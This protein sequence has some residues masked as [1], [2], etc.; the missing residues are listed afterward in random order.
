MPKYDRVSRVRH[1]APA[2][3]KDQR[4]CVPHKGLHKQVHH[5][6]CGWKRHNIS[7]FVAQNQTWADLTLA[8]WVREGAP[9]GLTLASFARHPPLRAV[10]AFSHASEEAVTSSRLSLVE[11]CSHHEAFGKHMP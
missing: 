7:L 9:Q 10:R 1:A 11:I 3:R 4:H 8:S 6:P 2:G 5:F